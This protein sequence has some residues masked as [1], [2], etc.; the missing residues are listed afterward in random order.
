MRDELQRIE[1]PGEHEARER[2][3]RVVATAFAERQPV[4]RR[5]RMVRPAIAI[6]VA[7]A[8]LAAVLSPP[9]RAVLD[10]IREAVGVERAQPAL[11]SLPTPG[12]LLVAS[13]AGVWVVQQDGSKRLLGEYR[14]ASWSPFGRFVVAARQNELA[15]LEPD[16]DVRW[17]LARPGVR[18]PRWTGTETDTRIAYVDR[19]GIRVVAGDGTGDRLLVPGARGPIAWRPGADHQLAHAGPSGRVAVIDVDTDDVLWRSRQDGKIAALEWSSNGRRL[20]ATRLGGRDA[21]AVYTARGALYTGFRTP[22]GAVTGSAMRP[23]SHARA[24]ALTVGNQARLF[25]PGVPGSALSGPGVL[26]DLAWS[27]DARWLL[28]GWPAADQLVLVRADGVRVRA[29]SNVSEQFRSRSFPRI[30]GWCCEP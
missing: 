14:E 22:R 21:L 12:R 13:D 23:G 26:R 8:A 18:F 6:A 5:P 15:A 29:V 19:T 1:V 24:V 9:G 30:E 3:W 28:V 25:M 7:A 11:F 4:E 10:E 2:T 17:T 27:P 16:G 20:V